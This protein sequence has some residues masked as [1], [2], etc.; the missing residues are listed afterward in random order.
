M[1]S[2]SAPKPLGYQ[3]TAVVKPELTVEQKVK[4][5]DCSKLTRAERG[6]LAEDIAEGYAGKG[7][8]VLP[9]KYSGNHGV[10]FSALSPEGNPLYGYEVKF[11][12]FGKFKPAPATVIIDKVKVPTHQ[13]SL[14]YTVDRYN[15]LKNAVPELKST[16]QPFIDNPSII[17]PGAMV[18]DKNGLLHIFKTE[19]MK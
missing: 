14:S 11:Q 6:L 5:Y 8:T 4:L 13:G 18:L 10:D 15:S 16:I 9:S 7:T 17:K 19:G 2:T 12:E 3:K 1:S